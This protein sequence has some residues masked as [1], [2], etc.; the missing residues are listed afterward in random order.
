MKKTILLLAI[1][2]MNINFIACTAEDV[3]ENLLIDDTQACC[4]ENGEILPPP[5]PPE[6]GE[7]GN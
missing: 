2:L 4:D 5:P 6:E 1:I 3:S 7:G